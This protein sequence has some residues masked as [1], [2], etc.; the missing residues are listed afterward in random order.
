MTEPEIKNEIENKIFTAKCGCGFS[1]ETIDAYYGYRAFD[2]HI[3]PNEPPDQPRKWYS[4]V[5]SPIGAV[6]IFVIGY[7]AYHIADMILH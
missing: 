4:Y 6:V 2:E 3:C 1:I 5:F 7:V